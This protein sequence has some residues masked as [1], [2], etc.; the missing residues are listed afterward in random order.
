MIQLKIDES[1]YEPEIRSGYFVSAEMKKIWAVELDL[2]AKFME[3]CEKNNLNYFVDAGTLLGAVRHKGFIPWDDDVDVMMPRKDYNKLFEIASQEFQYPYF[4]QNTLTENGF[5]RTHAQLRNS[6]TTGFIEI[7]SKKDINRGIFLDIFPLDGVPDSRVKQW[8]LKKRIETEKKILAYEYDRDYE[9][10]PLK[11][12]VNYK[13][14]HAF[15]KVVSFKKFFNHFNLKTLAKY[16]GK[17]TILIG[18]LSLKW[19]E[20]VHWKAEW[21]DGYV[22]L[23]FENLRVRAP[24]FYKEILTCLYGDFMKL[25]D[26]VT[27][28]NGRCHGT[29]TF[30]PDV[31][32]SDFVKG[33]K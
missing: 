2:L 17:K 6:S 18:D 1:F 16:S 12:K 15:F 26:D 19:R 5:F 30:D 32:Y 3:V 22:Y 13:L 28:A 21:F 23:Q 33:N 4:F 29:V 11:G 14:V 27:A 24:L 7:D 10:L 25:P 8:M 31:P 9:K 20:N